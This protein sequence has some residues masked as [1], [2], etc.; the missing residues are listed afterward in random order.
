MSVPIT[1]LVDDPC[2][3]VH[4]YRYHLEHVHA[5]EPRTRDGRPLVDVVPNQFLDAFCDVVDGY[6][7]RGKFSIVP[8]PAARG[9]IVSGINGD[10]SG[11][12]AWIATMRRRLGGAFDFCPEGITHDL[13]VNLADGSLLDKGESVWSQ[14]QDR[15]TLTPYLT[16]ALRYLKDAGIDATGVTSPWIFGQDVEGE[17]IAAIIDAQ[18]SVFGRERSWY[19][20]HMFDKKPGVRPWIAHRDGN[21]SLV[22]IASTVDDILWRSIDNPRTDRAF[23][24]EMADAILTADGFGGAVRAVLTAGGWPVLVTHWQSLYS[25]GLGT[26]LAALEE[27]ARRV[28]DA[29]HGEVEWASCSELMEMTLQSGAPRPAFLPPLPPPTRSP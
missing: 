15:S 11:T 16:R 8:A 19:F 13:T 24:L 7:L 4:V 12:R 2:P 29:L 26:G 21:A 18:L 22:S 1:L 25:N 6:G 28:R 27:V 10:P 20:L 9:D 17:Y 14:T 3:L 5:E 23:V